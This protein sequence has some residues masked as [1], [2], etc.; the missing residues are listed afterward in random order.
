METPLA[1]LKQ[2]L[3]HDF[4]N[5]RLVPISAFNWHSP[6]GGCGALPAVY[7][8][9]D[10]FRFV[11]IVD[12]APSIFESISSFQDFATRWLWTYNN[13]RSNMALVGITPQQ[14]L[15]LAA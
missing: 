8:T 5:G 10:N 11:P 2:F 15:E 13:E 7:E 3:I 12:K 6:N 9:R 1:G 4:K 14:K